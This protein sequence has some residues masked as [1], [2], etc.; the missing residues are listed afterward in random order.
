MQDPPPSEGGGLA[1]RV[2]TL[3]ENWNQ[4]ESCIFGAYEMI[5]GLNDQGFTRELSTV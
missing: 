5:K 3:L 1:S 4:L 2:D